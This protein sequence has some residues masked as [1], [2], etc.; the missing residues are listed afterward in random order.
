M[1]FLLTDLAIRVGDEKYFLIS[2]PK[3]MERVLKRTDS[4]V[5]LSTKEKNTLKNVLNWAHVL[6]SWL[7]N[8]NVKKQT[9]RSVCKRAVR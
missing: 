4:S 1:L 2:E 9:W 7:D 8:C 6:T 5:L 3:H